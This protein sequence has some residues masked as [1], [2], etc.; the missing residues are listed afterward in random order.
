MIP[1]NKRLERLNEPLLVSTIHEPAP[2]RPVVTPYG[3]KT[4]GEDGSV[5]TCVTPLTGDPHNLTKFTFEVTF[6]VDDTTTNTIH[7]IA[8]I[9]AENGFSFN[10]FDLLAWTEDGKI[11]VNIGDGTWHES[12]T[13]LDVFEV[14]KVHHFK[15]V[16]KEQVIEV[17]MDGVLF[18]F[19]LTENLLTQSS[20][21]NLGKRN[22]CHTED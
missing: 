18:N 10:N 15:L 13:M 6:K 19:A 8:T 4:T 22:G 3:V 7:P 20:R 14:G 17:Y 1:P 21:L 2:W 12:F 11:T 5:V 16:R 9:E